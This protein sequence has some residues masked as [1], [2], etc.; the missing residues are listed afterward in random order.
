MGVLEHTS[1]FLLAAIAKYNADHGVE[2]APF[3]DL[4]GEIAMIFA[5]GFSGDMPPGC[6]IVLLREAAEV[7][8]P[9]Y[10]PMEFQEQCRQ[11]LVAAES[12]DVQPE[13]DPHEVGAFFLSLLE[14]LHDAIDKPEGSIPNDR[15]LFLHACE[16]FF[17]QVRYVMA[18]KKYQ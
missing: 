13:K 16:S 6:L 7:D 8:E 2:K 5:F 18:K 17:Y 9:L 15:W 3:E 11:I 1:D 10:D 4:A 14:A 12:F